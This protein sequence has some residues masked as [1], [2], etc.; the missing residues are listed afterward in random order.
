MFSSPQSFGMHK[1]F[2]SAYRDVGASTAI[3]GASPHKLVSLL[4]GGLA[5]EIARARG[6]VGR[7]DV[8]TK[9]AAIGRAVRIVEEGLRAPLNM[10][11]GGEL[12]TNLAN[13]YEYMVQRLTFAN[14]HG[15]DAAL[16][17]CAQITQTL[18]EGWDGIADQVHVTSNKAAA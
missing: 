1:P 5:A 3:E 15:D 9:G 13:L 11:A 10:Q 8:A 7:G 16:A 6:A 14:L 12:A 2:A 18:R 17:E 4:Y